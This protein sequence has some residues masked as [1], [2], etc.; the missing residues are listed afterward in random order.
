MR[1]YVLFKSI[2]MRVRKISQGHY[3]LR[4]F[5]LSISME[6]LG[7]HEQI[8]VKFYILVFSKICLEYSISLK[9]NKHSGH[10]T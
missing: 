7:S 3:S 9:S 10:I 1:I 5:C 8:F 2:F 4:N 6:E